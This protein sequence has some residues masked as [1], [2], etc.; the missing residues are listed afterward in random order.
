METYEYLMCQNWVEQF[1]DNCADR[2]S[3]R[4]LLLHDAIYG[5]QGIN[6]YYVDLFG[7]HSAPEGDEV[8]RKRA[9][10]CPD[11]DIAEYWQND[12]FA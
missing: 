4:G 9:C 7:W 3:R 11:K 10:V 12:S 5:R 8:W 2:I 6:E 1:R